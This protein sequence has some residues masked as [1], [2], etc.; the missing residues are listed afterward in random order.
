[1]VTMKFFMVTI[2]LQG[3]SNPKASCNLLEVV[4]S[5][6]E[7]R[8]HAEKKRGVWSFVDFIVKLVDLRRKLW[9]LWPQRIACR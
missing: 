3:V 6:H 5:T 1:M 2:G 7:L 8:M 9:G 4:V